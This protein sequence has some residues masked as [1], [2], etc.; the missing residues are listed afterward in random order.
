MSGCGPTRRRL[1]CTWL[2][3][4]RRTLT[5]ALPPAARQAT[6]YADCDVADV[7]L[8]HSLLTPEPSLPALT[9]LRLT[10]ARYG[11]V[12]RHYIELTQ[13]RAVTPEL[14]RRMVAQSPCA[15]VQRIEASHSAYFSQPA[16]LSAAIGRIA[17]PSGRKANRRRPG[18]PD[19]SG[20]TTEDQGARRSLA[21]LTIPKVRS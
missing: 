3:I 20:A 10:E 2:P 19:A 12:A 4:C 16:A 18:T 5:D 13:D 9:R 21:G 15:S 11:R 1:V 8:A 17:F 14:Q 6:L 7:A